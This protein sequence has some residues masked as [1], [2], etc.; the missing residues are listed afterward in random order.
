MKIHPG[1]YFSELCERGYTQGHKEFFDSRKYHPHKINALL[2]ADV[3]IPNDYSFDVYIRNLNNAPTNDS[4]LDLIGKDLLSLAE[5]LVGSHHQP[6]LRV[7]SLPG[8]DEYEYEL[9]WVDSN[10][11][12]EVIWNRLRFNCEDALLLLLK[13][14]EKYCEFHVLPMLYSNKHNV[15]QFKTSPLYRYHPERYKQ[16]RDCFK[17]CLEIFRRNIDFAAGMMT[18][19]DSI[20]ELIAPLVSEINRKAMNTPLKDRVNENMVH[21]VVNNEVNI[22]QNVGLFHLFG[23]QI[24]DIDTKLTDMFKKTDVDD[25][26]LNML[27][28]PFASQYIFFGRQ[29]DIELVPGWCFDGA[30]VEKFPSDNNLRITITS[31]PKVDSQT[32]LWYI[33][34]EPIYHQRIPNA[35]S[36]IDLI[37]AITQVFS[38][39]IQSIAS[40]VQTDIPELHLPNGLRLVD[41]SKRNDK[42]RL[43]HNEKGFEAFIKAIRLIANSVCYLSAYP[44]D[45]DPVWPDDAPSTLVIKATSVDIKVAERAQSKLEKLGY[46]KLRYYGKHYE[47][48]FE[49]TIGTGR[50]SHWR[51]GHWRRQAYGPHSSLRKMIWLMPMLVGN[52]GDAEIEGHIYSTKA[53]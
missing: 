11:G 24:I 26:P 22:L 47:H 15:K 6:Q 49:K 38:D 2:S 45:S 16:N 19:V 13:I 17:Y 32:R 23:K 37:T 10:V 28:L 43:S 20:N 4:V 12:S 44:D 29:D 14:E 40:R 1:N 51:R 3:N 7:S 27:Q 5:H 21:M 42:D 36:S 25:I 50:A 8:I 33:K 53:P 41:V 48:N 34:P 35:D 18:S 52:P 9:F 30:Y 46:H 31:V 39:A